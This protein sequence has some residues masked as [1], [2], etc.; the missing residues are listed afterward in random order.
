M[1][2][3]IGELIKE[4]EGK[5]ISILVEAYKSGSIDGEENFIKCELEE[6]KNLLFMRNE[7]NDKLIELM[8][9]KEE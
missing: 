5:I 2:N 6:I 1:K 7:L 8:G 9:G 4:T 3:A